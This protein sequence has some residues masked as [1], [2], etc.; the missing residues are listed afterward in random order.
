MRIVVSVKRFNKAINRLHYVAGARTLLAQP[1]DPQQ[2]TDNESDEVLKHA[3]RGRDRRRRARRPPRIPPLRRLYLPGGQGTSHA[4]ASPFGGIATIVSAS[5]YVSTVRGDG[6]QSAMSLPCRSDNVSTFR[7]EERRRDV[8]ALSA[9]D[10]V[11][12]FAPGKL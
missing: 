1:R 4:T 10:N 11:Q 5:D 2:L 6:R 7:R 8:V 12:R 3:F 9:P